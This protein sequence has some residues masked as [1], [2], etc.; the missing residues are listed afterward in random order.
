MGIRMNTPVTHKNMDDIDLID[1]GHI[2]ITHVPP[3]E[4]LMLDVTEDDTGL[5]LDKFLAMKLPEHSRTRLKALVLDGAVTID[6]I[7][8][9]DPNRK[10]SAGMKVSLSMP[11]ATPPE[12]QAEAIPLDIV[13]EDDDL[14]VINKPAG[15]VVHPAAGHTT[16][17][18][19][20][21][22]IAHCGESLQ[23]LAG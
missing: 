14:I 7:P 11:E 23:G 5:R 21:A 22:L 18:L 10:L 9:G 15:L 1:E 12:P 16:G 6:G 20:N 13:Y 3:N 19:V 2:A 17:T 8:E 4:E